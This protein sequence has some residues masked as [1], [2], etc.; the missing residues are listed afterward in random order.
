MTSAPL[1]FAR[2]AGPPA[3]TTMTGSAQQRSMATSVASLA[4]VGA[5]VGCGSALPTLAEAEAEAEDAMRVITDLLPPAE[6]EDL[7]S[8][9]LLGCGDD[10]VLHTGHW[11]L[12]MARDF[13]GDQFVESLPARLPPGFQKRDLGSSASF[14][15]ASFTYRDIELQLMVFPVEGDPVVDILAIS[16]CARAPETE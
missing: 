2:S 7:T 13:D 12:T 15:E 1:R 3:G 9:M 4:L 6:L 11:S 10:G 5:L 8:D 16:R 14:P